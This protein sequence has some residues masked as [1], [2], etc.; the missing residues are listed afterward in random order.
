MT[1]E[2]DQRVITNDSL[3]GATIVFDVLIALAYFAIPLQILY[4]RHKY[5]LYLKNIILVV[6]LFIGF[7]FFCG[8]THA[9][10][11]YAVITGRHT[12]LVILKGITCIVSLTTALAMF[13]VIPDAID[14][15][16]NLNKDRLRLANEMLSYVNHEIRNPLQSI[17]GYIQC[18]ISDLENKDLEFTPDTVESLKK[19]LDTCFSSCGFMNHI[20]NDVLDVKRLE[21]KRLVLDITEFDV[22]DLYYNTIRTIT[23]KIEQ[24]NIKFIEEYTGNSETIIKTDYRRLQQILINLL[25]NAIKYSRTWVKFWGHSD[26]NYT[27][28]AV[29]DDGLGISEEANEFIFQPFK[30]TNEEDARRHNGFGLG[31][32]LC[33]MLC[34]LLNININYVSELGSGTMFYVVI[35]PDKNKIS[36]NTDYKGAIFI[37]FEQS[38]E[39]L[40]NLKED[41]DEHFSVII[42]K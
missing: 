18:M 3:L 7:I 31:L 26:N 22:S 20:V 15:V 12:I 38:L 32:Y 25:T 16:D 40:P 13:K 5:D 17:M 19:Y 2:S 14:K 34:D 6:M 39:P 9:F 11:I 33:K 37:N 23:P 28:I 35:G 8:L 10:N 42:S 4:Y 21:Q 29:M 27:V 41:K 36:L 1:E 24:K 30:A